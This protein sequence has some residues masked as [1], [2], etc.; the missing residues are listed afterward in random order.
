MKLNILLEHIEKKVSDI[1]QHIHIEGI[2]TNSSSI[3]PN[4]LFVAI[5]GYRV[6]GHNFI[7]HALEAGASAIVGEKDLKGL[8]VPYI[9]V[10]NSRLALAKIACQFYGNP[11]EKKSINGIT[12][13]N[14]KTTTSFM[15]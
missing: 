2:S 15:L 4:D 10:S 14:G 12:G 1:I 9:Q 5:P 6:D 8:S 13:T 11:S 7:E 3:H